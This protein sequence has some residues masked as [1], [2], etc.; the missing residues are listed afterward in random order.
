M[1]V[2]TAGVDGEST[3]V[4]LLNAKTSYSEWKNDSNGFANLQQIQ[5]FCRG[6]AWILGQWAARSEA[7]AMGSLQF[8]PQNIVTWDIFHHP[9]ETGNSKPATYQPNHHLESH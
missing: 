8:S 2:Y 4:H 5:V 9:L 1:Y 3:L 6:N 7:M